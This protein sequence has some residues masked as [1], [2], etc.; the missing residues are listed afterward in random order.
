MHRHKAE[1][2]DLFFWAR[3]KSTFLEKLQ[4]YDD[5]IDCDALL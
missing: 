3:E 1:K 5:L 4:T 2:T